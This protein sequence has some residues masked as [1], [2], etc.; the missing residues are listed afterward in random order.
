MDS[1]IIVSI[2]IYLA[3]F[4]TGGAIATCALYFKID[5]TLKIDHSDSKKDV[6]RIEIGDLDVL[7]YKKHIVLKVENDADLRWYFVKNTSAIMNVS[8]NYIF[9]RSYIN[10]RK[11][12]AERGAWNRA[13]RT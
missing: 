5:G 12:N 13:R 11:I 10:E 8:S 3:G 6:Y 4:F 2:L 9:E 7:P 1:T